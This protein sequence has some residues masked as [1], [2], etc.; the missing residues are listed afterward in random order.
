MY[1]MRVNSG[2][3]AR[4]YNKDLYKRAG[5]DPEKPPET[6]DELLTVVGKISALGDEIWGHYIPTAPVL[7]T[8]GDYFDQVLWS[9]GGDRISEDG[10]KITLDTPEAVK[11]FTFYKDLIDAKGMPAKDV[12]ETVMTND[13]LT[14]NVGSM[15]AF[16]ALLGRVAAA[17]FEGGSAH[18]L[19]GPA[20][21][22]SPLGFGP[23]KS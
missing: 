15:A 4:L 12:N 18:P 20:G 23:S 16:P 5:L 10:K 13:F 7:Q 22:V 17:K 11:A 14:G 3:Q 19:K 2:V 8:G 1:A 9:M 6:F 21:A